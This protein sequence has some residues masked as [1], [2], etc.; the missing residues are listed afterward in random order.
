MRS[1]RRREAAKNRAT[2]LIEDFMIAANAWS[3]ASCS[4]C[5]LSAAS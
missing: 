1:D 4:K 5:L 3:R 2:E